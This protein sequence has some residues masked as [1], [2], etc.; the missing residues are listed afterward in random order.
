MARSPRGDEPLTLVLALA[1]QT[2]ERRVPS[3]LISELVVTHRG[4]VYPWQ[5][6]QNGHRTA[7]DDYMAL[8]TTEGIVLGPLWCS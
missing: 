5:C 6:D 2:P 1:L 8:L 3:S 4:V 7:Y